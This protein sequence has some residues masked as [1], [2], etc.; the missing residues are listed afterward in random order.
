MWAEKGSRARGVRQA[1]LGS[2]DL[3]AAVGPLT[4]RAC[5]AVAPALD[6]ATIDFV[7]RHSSQE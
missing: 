3:S 5:G 1:H 6:V 7:L 2:P 4:R